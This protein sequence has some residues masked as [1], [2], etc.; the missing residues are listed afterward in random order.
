MDMEYGK[1]ILEGVFEKI[2]ARIEEEDW[3]PFCFVKQHFRFDEFYK[4]FLFCF[5]NGDFCF[6]FTVYSNEPNGDWLEDMRMSMDLFISEQYGR[7]YLR[8]EEIIEEPQIL[9]KLYG[10]VKEEMEYVYNQD[11]QLRLKYVLNSEKM[12]QTNT[13]LYR[14]L[15]EIEKRE[16]WKRNE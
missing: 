10:I 1:E 11:K 6:Q 8:H 3:Y 9:K 5:E 7:R 12:L 16:G 14:V 13:D 2:I 4:E 15:K